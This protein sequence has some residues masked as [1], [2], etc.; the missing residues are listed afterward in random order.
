VSLPLFY[1]SKLTLQFAHRRV[2]L[3]DYRGNVVLDTLVRPTY[4]HE[5]VAIFVTL[6]DI[7]ASNEVTNY[8][9]TETGLVASHLTNGNFLSIP[10]SE[11][12]LTGAYPGLSAPV[13]RS[14]TSCDDAYT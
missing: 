14:P 9:T 5:I 2:S 12:R 11:F 6:I 13:S 8:R 4:V 7:S 1:R 10:P 3:A